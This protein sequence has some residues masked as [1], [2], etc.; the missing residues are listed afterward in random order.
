MNSEPRMIK[1]PT[2]T[3]EKDVYSHEDVFRLFI[4]GIAI[5]RGDRL[6]MEYYSRLI[7]NALAIT[8]ATP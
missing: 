8:K 1:E 2:V 6:S 7:S 3:V 4:N 5:V